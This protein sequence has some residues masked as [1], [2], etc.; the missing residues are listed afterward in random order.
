MCG[1]A[2]GAALIFV[3]NFHS[4]RR[5]AQFDG[6]FSKMILPFRAFPIFDHLQRSRLP[7]VDKRD[8]VAVCTLNLGCRHQALF[9]AAKLR[10]RRRASSVSSVS[11][12]ARGKSDKADGAIFKGRSHPNMNTDPAPGVGAETGQCARTHFMR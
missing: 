9:F 5:P 8:P 3:D 4:T 11:I 7:H 6:P 1:G 2:P 10:R 12:G